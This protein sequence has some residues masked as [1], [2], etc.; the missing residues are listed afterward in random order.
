M[1]DRILL[2]SNIGF[3]HGWI[4]GNIVSLREYLLRYGYF[5]DLAFYSVEF[6]DFLSKAHPELIE[7]DYSSGDWDSCFHELYFAG[8]CFLHEDP[9]I[10]VL[11]ALNMQ[12]ENKDIFEYR[13]KPYLRSEVADEMLA[14][15]CTLPGHQ[16]FYYESVLE[17]CRLAE[18]FLEKK[19]QHLYSK[20]YGT[21]GFSCNIAQFYT[22]YWIAQCL[23]ENN[24]SLNII[25]GGPMFMD[26]NLEQYRRYFPSVNHFIAGKG[27]EA[28]LKILYETNP[29]RKSEFQLNNKQEIDN[30]FEN[31]AN[32]Y[33]DAYRSISTI[34]QNNSC[35]P[36][37][38]QTWLGRNCS[39]A[40]CEFCAETLHPRI[41]REA[42]ITV[43]E[44]KYLQS[45]LGASSIGFAEPDVN[46]SKKIFEDLLLK[47]SASK[48]Q[49]HL[50]CELNARNTSKNILRLMKEVGFDDFQIGIEALSNRLLQKMN[51]PSTVLDNIKVLKWSRDVGLTNFCF[52]LLCFFPGEDEIDLMETQKL[53]ELIP[54]LL[55]S[56]I[57][58]YLAEYEL[59]RPAKLYVTYSKMNKVEDYEFFTMAL[60]ESF[61]SQIPFWRRKPNSRPINPLWVTI[62]EF[63][64]S[65]KSRDC[66]LTW[67]QEAD[68]IVIDDLRSVE[69]RCIILEGI[70]CK[71]LLALNNYVYTAQLLSEELGIQIKE[72]NKELD[73]LGT[74]GLLYSERGFYISLVNDYIA[75][76]F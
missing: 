23:K 6:S 1:Q 61:R 63:I 42:D 34:I 66:S 67:R 53:L 14:G 52:N 25:F 58:V 9:T 40:R 5:V 10:L 27:E 24:P 32:S 51:K 22:S 38:F 70:S 21:I 74:L 17:Y 11:R 2:I 75:T 55:T 43:Q 65:L 18:R 47:L 45:V 59:L 50:W 37:T 26:W 12:C 60:P 72:V 56:P 69:A 31:S 39:W 15:V 19:I 48:P 71:L 7:I 49:G 30:D 4:P 64:H 33:V 20:N 54:H 73:R 46:G 13:L 62:A 57:T 44:I 8:K 29:H 35:I 28:L 68:G 3:T 36:W 16:A 41:A 76:S